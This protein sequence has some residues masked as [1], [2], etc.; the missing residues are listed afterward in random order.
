Y[1]PS[2]AASATFNRWHRG[3]AESLIERFSLRKKRVV[4]IGC[5][6]GEFLTLLAE[7]GGNECV[8]YDPMLT[9]ESMEKVDEGSVRLLGEMFTAETEPGPTDFICCKMTL[10]HIKDV[11]K[12]VQM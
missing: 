8:G 12:F 3:L 4:E 2:Q 5:V 10:E 9:G 1:N 11:R 6:Q 7:C